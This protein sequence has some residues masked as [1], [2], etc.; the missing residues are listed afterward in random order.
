MC[1]RRLLCAAYR[2]QGLDQHLHLGLKLSCKCFGLL[3]LDP[4]VDVLLIELGVT[5][6]VGFSLRKLELGGLKFCR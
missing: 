1:V 6:I 4:Q 2:G 5:N 3:R